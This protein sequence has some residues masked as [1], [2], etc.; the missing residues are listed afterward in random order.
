MIIHTATELIVEEQASYAVTGVFTILAFLPF[1]AIWV[2]VFME[3]KYT[4]TKDKDGSQRNMKR[5]G[6]AAIVFA[7]F[8]FIALGSL[9][10]A[11]V[12]TMEAR[13]AWVGSY[14]LTA[15]SEQM[16][17][18]AFPDKTPTE[19]RGFGEAFMLAQDDEKV[20]V[21]LAWR[22]DEFVLTGTD[23]QPLERLAD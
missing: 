7:V 6:R 9:L 13:H 15:T 12:A 21:R 10:T 8:A 17:E 18:L 3:N 20:A 1:V 16:K 14:G 22:D 2:F 23:G 19:E 5:I 4:Q 11:K